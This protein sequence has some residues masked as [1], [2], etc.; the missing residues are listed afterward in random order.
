META[1]SSRRDVLA[2]IWYLDGHGASLFGWRGDTGGMALWDIRSESKCTMLIFSK[3][4]A[5]SSQ[6]YKATQADH[7][8]S[9]PIPLA[10]SNTIQFEVTEWLDHLNQSVINA[11]KARRSLFDWSKLDK[12]FSFSDQSSMKSHKFCFMVVHHDNWQSYVFPT[13]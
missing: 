9:V 3:A 8:E 12:S 1:S 7:K 6:E 10:T 13:I 2:E 5:D 4:Y 11:P